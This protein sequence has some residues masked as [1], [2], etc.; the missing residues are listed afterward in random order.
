MNYECAE[1]KGQLHEKIDR[2]ILAKGEQ[3]ANK[4]C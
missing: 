1:I 2:G 3:N 4:K